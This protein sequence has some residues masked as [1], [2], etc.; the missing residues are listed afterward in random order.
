MNGRIYDPQL[1]RF[2]SADMVVQYHGNLQS[3]NRFSYVRNNPLSL[4]DPGG[5]RDS[6]PPGVIAA[7]NA[8]RQRWE[9][10][11]GWKQVP[12]GAWSGT[13]RGAHDVA[14]GIGFLAGAAVGGIEYQVFGTTN[15]VE[16]TIEM[17]NVNELRKDAISS[18]V[19]DVMGVSNEG[20]AFKGIERTSQVLTD[21]TAPIAPPGVSKLDDVKIATKVDGTVDEILKVSDDASTNGSGI[22]RT[23]WGAE[24]GKGNVEHNN[25]IENQLDAAEDR[26]ATDM[27]KNRVQRDAE[28]N[29]VRTPDG[30]YTRPDAS[31]VEDGVRY[32]GNR[33]S[34][35]NNLDRE[36]EAFL[37]MIE[38]DPNAV[39]F[40]E[41]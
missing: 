18:D 13:S 5:Y 25:W 1:G 33:T 2:L 31:W 9:A 41:F 35:L 15:V 30:G 6:P 26:G 32:N 29:R 36:T 17:G 27:R 19:A 24:H 4:W 21:L 14:Y 11:G 37:K 20:E 10:A 8:A 28:G 23:N 40:W 16:F 22:S 7:H 3:Y 39:N 38:A 12:A 34:N